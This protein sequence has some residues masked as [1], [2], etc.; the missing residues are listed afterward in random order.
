MGIWGWVGAIAAG[1]F[2][3]SV[4]VVVAWALGM[5]RILRQPPTPPTDRSNVHHIDARGGER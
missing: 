1:W 4:V 3:A 5:R 2:A